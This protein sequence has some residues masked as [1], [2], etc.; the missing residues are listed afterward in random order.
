MKTYL[1]TALLAAVAIN[2]TSCSKQLDL[3]PVSNTSTNNFYSNAND[4]AQAVTG[5]YSNLTNYPTQALWLG[6]LRSDNIYGTD[7]GNRDWA[8]INNFA[9]NISSTGYITTAWNENFNGVYNANSVLQALDQKGTVIKDTALASRYRAEAR[10]LRGFYYF[11]LVKLFG[12]VPV[13]TSPLSAAEVAAVPRSEI[14]AVYDLIISDFVYAA[15]VLPPTY[16]GSN[17]GR[18]TSGAANGYLGLVYLTRSG[19]TYNVSGPGLNSNEYD[20]ALTYLNKVVSSG[21]YDILPSYPNVFSYTNENNKEVVFDIQF[22]SSSNGASFPSHLVPVA[23]W[24]SL[25]YASTYGNGYG[26]S[27]FDITNNL[28]TSYRP[29][30]VVQDV[31]DTFSVNYTYGVSTFYKKYIDLSRK[32]STGTDW[33]VN[34]IALRY[35]DV[36]LLKAE[37]ILHG[38]SGTQAEADALV[39]KIRN[40]GGLGSINQV[41]TAQLLE[42]R[43]R[44]FAGEGIRWNDLVRSGQA[45][46]IMNAWIAA[47]NYGS[48]INQ[49]IPNHVIYPVPS[50]EITTSNGLYKQ[51]EGY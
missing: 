4:F 8:G 47:D 21:V 19:P 3:T 5:A 17:T 16:T 25:G 22:M 33:P 30:G 6:E 29:N 24:T 44:E 28:R 46:T 35:A 1:Y 18:A 38:G 37:A 20:K 14:S 42:E 43:R 41:T 13:L 32:G 2:T 49:V 36:L 27:A 45:V 34:F 12:K 39:N 10:F 50:A 40:R 26:S 51:N 9:T 15:S 48:T 11:Q 23:Y 31:R 7:D